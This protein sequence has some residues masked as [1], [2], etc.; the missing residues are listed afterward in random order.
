MRRFIL[1]LFPDSQLKIVVRVF[2]CSARLNFKAKKRF[3]IKCSALCSTKGVR[4]DILAELW[5]S[6][7]NVSP[8]QIIHEAE[9]AVWAYWRWMIMMGQKSS[10]DIINLFGGDSEEQSIAIK[11]YLFSK[12][13]AKLYGKK[14]NAPEL[15]FAKKGYYR[16]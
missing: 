10:D 5:F 4:G 1:P 8:L 11:E 12:I 6:K 16:W 9:H 3:N 2:D 15:W 13:A 14:Y 7:E